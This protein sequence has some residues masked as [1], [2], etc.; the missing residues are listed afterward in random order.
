MPYWMFDAVKYLTYAIGNKFIELNKGII[1]AHV[2]IRTWFSFL[3]EHGAKPYQRKVTKKEINGLLLVNEKSG[4]KY[5]GAKFPVY[6]KETENIERHYFLNDFQIY[7]DK[8]ARF[9]IR[10]NEKSNGFVFE[11]IFTNT[12]KIFSIKKS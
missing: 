9:V 3:I 8:L 4:I 1:S 2:T 12:I 10:C 5:K 7:S 11:R 6:F